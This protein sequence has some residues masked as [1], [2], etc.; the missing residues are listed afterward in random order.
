ME[1]KNSIVNVLLT[2]AA[3]AAGSW[4]TLNIWD[5]VDKRSRRYTELIKGD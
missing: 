3:F 2:L 1:K 4:L 5:R